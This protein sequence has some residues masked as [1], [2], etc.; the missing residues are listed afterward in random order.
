MYKCTVC[1]QLEERWEKY[2]K[3][4]QFVHEEEERRKKEEEEEKEKKLKRREKLFKMLQK[5][6]EGW[7]AYLCCQLANM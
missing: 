1:L 4:A 5:R 2:E 6:E 3:H 7:F